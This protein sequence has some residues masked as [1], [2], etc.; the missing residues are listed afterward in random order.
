M[1]KA[2][3]VFHV[4]DTIWFLSTWIWL[5]AGVKSTNGKSTLS[6]STRGLWQEDITKKHSCYNHL[7]W[8]LEG[9]C[10]CCCC[11]LNLFVSS[12]IQ[13]GKCQSAEFVSTETLVFLPTASWQTLLA[14]E[15]VCCCAVRKITAIS[16]HP[17]QAGLS[18][19]S[20]ERRLD[21]STSHQANSSC[22]DYLFTTANTIGSNDF[23]GNL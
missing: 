11:C 23:T 3:D 10:W 6:F 17:S 5:G 16:F 7:S 20:A 21:L 14:L 9:C 1:R 12:K 18:E 8:R 13:L 19:A 2:C 4:T 15:S 22:E